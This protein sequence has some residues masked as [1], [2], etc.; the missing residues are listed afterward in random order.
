MITVH[1]GSAIAFMTLAMKLLDC[2]EQVETI[3]GIKRGLEDI[4]YG[5]TRPVEEFGQEMLQ[6]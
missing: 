3:A 4:E 2:I 1:K 6:K 5:R